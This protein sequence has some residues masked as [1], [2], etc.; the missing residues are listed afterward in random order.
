MS[1]IDR[2]SRLTA[3]AV[4]AAAALAAH[5]VAD[6]LPPSMNGGI[7]QKS[8]DEMRTLR[9]SYRLRMAFVD[10][11]SGAPLSGVTVVITRG[12]NAGEI[13]FHDCGPLFF[14]AAER[15]VYRVSATHE[16]V[17]QSQLVDLRRGARDLTFRWPAV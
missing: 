9:S 3:A 2:L 14:V 12:D 10:A 13:R 7:G 17:T 6:R 5:A 4:V 11:A 8:Q 1:R 15:G 16:G